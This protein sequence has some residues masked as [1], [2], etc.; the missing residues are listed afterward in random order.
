MNVCVGFAIP[1]A[2]QSIGLITLQGPAHTVAL[3]LVTIDTLHTFKQDCPSSHWWHIAAATLHKQWQSCWLWVT[4]QIVELSNL[5]N[6]WQMWH[7]TLWDCGAKFNAFLLQCKMC[8]NNT[9]WT[10]WSM[11]NVNWLCWHFQMTQL[12]NSANDTNFWVSSWI[13][14]WHQMTQFKTSV[15]WQSGGNLVVTDHHT[16]LTPRRKSNWWGQSSGNLGDRPSH[17]TT[18]RRKSDRQGQLSG[19][20]LQVFSVSRPNP[21]HIRHQFT[22]TIA[23]H[24]HDR[25]HFRFCQ[26]RLGRCGFNWYE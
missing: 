23:V 17:T 9:Q 6:K 16:S 22:A 20:L 11:S 26:R 8:T 2:H 21:R 19:L 18:P 7:Q 13:V 14:I 25:S 10:F 5:N 3:E 12:D 15:K 1:S 4:F 24:M